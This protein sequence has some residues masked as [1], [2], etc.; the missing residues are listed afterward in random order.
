M[1]RVASVVCLVSASLIACGDG[2]TARSIG[3]PLPD[4]PKPSDATTPSGENC[5]D[6]IDNN[7][8]GLVDCADPACAGIAMCA[9]AVPNGWLG[10]AELYE[11]AAMPSLGCIAPWTQELVPGRT[12]PSGTPATCGACACGAPNAQ[13]ACLPS[14]GAATVAPV[15]FASTALACEGAS[16]S[17]SD[18]GCAGSACV[19]APAPAFTAGLCVHATGVEACPAPYT[20]RHVYFAGV[21]DTRGCAPCACAAATNGACASSGGTPDGGVIG[22]APST[23]CCLPAQ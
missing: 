3:A 13:G 14:G 10:H 20:V 12:A 7:G 22:T 17:P 6:G 4:A 23:F 9:P 5:F 2:S 1:V 16:T 11:G 15:T 19:A 8:N 18:A 21:S